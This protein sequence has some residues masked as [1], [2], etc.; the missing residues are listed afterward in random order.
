[1]VKNIDKKNHDQSHH[2]ASTHQ[3]TACVLTVS[4]KASRGERIDTGG[5]LICEMLKSEGFH[6]VHTDTV[7][8]EQHLIEKVLISFADEQNIALVVTTGGT[9]FSPRDLTP[10]ATLAVCERM[11]PGIPE[12]M[13]AESMKITNRAM[14]SRLVSGIRGKTLII[15]LPGSPKAIRENLAV[16]LPALAHGLDVLRGDQAD[17]GTE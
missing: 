9:G 3:Y 8:D 7:A 13:R 11:V 6:I 12:A 4:D 5:P 17:C 10:E 15:N 16:I 1:M 14:L 2:G